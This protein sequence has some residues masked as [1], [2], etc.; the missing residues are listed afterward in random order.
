MWPGTVMR[1]G[2]VPPGPDHSLHRRLPVYRVV[3]WFAL[4]T[5]QTSPDGSSSLSPVTLVL[6]QCLTSWVGGGRTGADP[7]PSANCSLTKITGCVLTPCERNGTTFLFARAAVTGPPTGA[8]PTDRGLLVLEASAQAPEGR[9][10]PLGLAPGHGDGHLPLCLC[11][12]SS[13]CTACVQIPEPTLMTS[14]R[15]CDQMRPQS[16]VRTPEYTFWGNTIQPIIGFI[17]KIQR[18]RMAEYRIR[19]YILNGNHPRDISS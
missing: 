14:V 8:Q 7:T 3:S 18:M 4:R 2:T 19:V 5:K 13:R 12:A 15:P 1:P 9:P 11:S 16:E 17:C 10:V 6:S